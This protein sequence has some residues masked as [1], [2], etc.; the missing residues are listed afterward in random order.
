M[1]RLESA[2]IELE[3]KVTEAEKAAA[4]LLKAAKQLR[5]AA[6]LG[7]IQNLER[8]LEVVAER[9]VEAAAAA[10]SL[11]GEWSFDTRGYLTSGYAS[12]LSNAATEKGVKLFE[13]EGQLF[14]FPLLLTVD[15]R[16]VVVR[17]G[18]K[19]ER[20]IRPKQ[21][22]EAIAKTQKRPQLQRGQVSCSAVRCLFAAGGIGMEKTRTAAWPSHFTRPNP[23][24]A[25]IAPGIRLSDRRVRPRPPV[26]RSAA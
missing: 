10:R 4:E 12:E 19:R 23:C 26:A 21:L 24:S 2:L 14:A 11:K 15:P 5:Q 16:E 13:R 20:N 3:A 25:D 8:G 9:G 7:N 17:V 22:V 1:Q 18:R 6:R